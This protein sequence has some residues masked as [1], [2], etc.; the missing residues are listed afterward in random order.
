MALS[1]PGVSSWGELSPTLGASPVEWAPLFRLAGMEE[2]RPGDLCVLTAQASSLQI[3]AC[4]AQVMVGTISQSKLWAENSH[5]TFLVVDEPSQVFVELLEGPCRPIEDTD[6]W[7]EERELIERFGVL[8]RTAMVHRAASIGMSV[9]LGAGAVIHPRVRL[10]DGVQIGEGTVVGAAGFGLAMV[11]GK[12]R[13]L[14]HWAGVEIGGGTWIGPQCQISA[15]LLSPTRI[16]RDCHLDAQIQVGHNCQVGD[17]CV[18]A[19]QSGLAGSVVL[20]RQCLLG[21]QVGVSDHVQLGDHC[22]VAARA[23]VTRSWPPE[24][25]LRGFPARPGIPRG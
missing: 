6:D 8:S 4:Q 23:G 13:H 17:G 12:I 21:G 3:R 10:A 5:Q 7:M 24:T 2:A 9:V 25:V 18:L 11:Q 14:P 19:G 1:L 20:G 16:G 15:G 22:V